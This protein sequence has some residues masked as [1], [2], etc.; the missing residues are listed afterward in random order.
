M[1]M[2]SA[3]ALNRVLNGILTGPEDQSF[4]RVTID[5]RQVQKNDLFV[6]IIGEKKD[7]HDYIDQARERGAA[8]FLVSRDISPGADCFA[9]KVEDTL[10]GLQTLAAHWRDLY[11][12]LIIGITGSNGKTTTKDL[13]ASVLSRSR[14]TLKTPG[15][16]NNQYGLPLALLQLGSEDEV[17]VLEMGM[18]SPGEIALLSSIARPDIGI[19]TNI[20][21]AH[22]EFLQDLEGVARAKNEL[23]E[24]LPEDGVLIFNGDDPYVVGLAENYPG[25]RIS[26]GFEDRNQIRGEEIKKLGYNHIALGVTIADKF[27]LFRVP[28][29]GKHN[30]YNALAAIA[31]GWHL[32]IS[33]TSIGEGLLQVEL[34]G[35]RMEIQMMDKGYLLINDSYNANPTSM[36]YALDIV[37]E[38]GGDRKIALLGDMLELGAGSERLHRELG[39]YIADMNLDLLLTRGPGGHLIGRGARDR[40]MPSRR[41]IDLENNQEAVKFLKKSLRSKDTVLIKG[42]RGLKMEEI[43]QGLKD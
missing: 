15:N 1:P 29:V 38:I 19:L 21:P 43:V 7:G 13:V 12:P 42:S 26:F 27:Q 23:V 14:P 32:G 4:S 11:D 37:Q 3:K 36:R 28:L 31:V 34:S 33:K 17:A 25:T 39:Q 40:G 9:V 2:M 22:L 41:I 30:A 5:S 18:N 20:G 6:A 10:E 24:A 8:G 35:N 16:L